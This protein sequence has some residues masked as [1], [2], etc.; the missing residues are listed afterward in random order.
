MKWTEK[1][2]EQKTK[3]KLG[4]AN[5][6]TIGGLHLKHGVFSVSQKYVLRVL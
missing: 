5:S 2:V 1:S 6:E 3:H 4:G